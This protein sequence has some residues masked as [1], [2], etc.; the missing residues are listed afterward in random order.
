MGSLFGENAQQ[1]ETAHDQCKKME[2][3]ATAVLVKVGFLQQ[4][5]MLMHTSVLLGGA[6]GWVDAL[7]EHSL[8]QLVHSVLQIAAVYPVF[9]GISGSGIC[10]TVC[11]PANQSIHQVCLEMDVVGRGPC[12]LK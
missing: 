12:G 7:A 6:V 1:M 5:G 8:S 11:V 9:R 2:D 4:L 10:S 3:S